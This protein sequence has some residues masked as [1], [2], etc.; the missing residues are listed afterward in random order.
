MNRSGA[1]LFTFQLHNDAGNGCIDRGIHSNVRCLIMYL[2]CGRRIAGFFTLLSNL[3]TF[4][5]LRTT[6]TVFYNFIRSVD[7]ACHVSMCLDQTVSIHLRAT[8]RH[9]LCQTW[10]ADVRIIECFVCILKQND[11][12]Y[13]IVVENI[14]SCDK[15]NCSLMK[16]K[17]C[18][19]VA[20]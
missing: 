5:E 13:I 8:K 18:C 19:F 7:A 2:D 1:A 12:M 16:I 17:R 20:N 3:L 4:I 6:N 15:F 10:T 9:C 11:Y 14:F